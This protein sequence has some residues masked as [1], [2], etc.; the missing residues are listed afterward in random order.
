M[1]IIELE[2]PEAMAR[3][4]RGALEEGRSSVGRSGVA[5]VNGFCSY[6]NAS[7]VLEFL[8]GLPSPKEV[9]E[10]RPAESLSQRVSDLLEKSRNDILTSDERSELDL[11][12][13][14]DHLVRI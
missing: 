12:G 5:E 1:A 9:L 10:L 11:Y 8:A 14:L 4:I 2:V 13:Y 7:Q 3:Q 6:E